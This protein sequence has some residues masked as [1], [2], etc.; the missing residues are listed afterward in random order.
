M[1]NCLSK[2]RK[3]ELTFNPSHPRQ[4]GTSVHVRGL[5]EMLTKLRLSETQSLANVTLVQKS[6]LPKRRIY[7]FFDAPSRR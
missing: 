6:A 4:I 3:S 2:L 7:N 5:N 1:R